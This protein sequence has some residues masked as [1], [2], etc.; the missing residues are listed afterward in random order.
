MKASTDYENYKMVSTKLDLVG[1][2]KTIGSI[3]SLDFETTALRPDEGRVRLAQIYDGTHG[4]VIDFDEIKGGFKAVASMFL[5]KTWIVFNS[6]FELRWFYAVGV[7]PLCK[8]VAFLRCSILGGGRYSLKQV[9][10]W[11]LSREMDK[12]EQ[13]SDWNAP[14][15]TPQQLRYAFRDAVDTWDLYQHW[16]GRADL[17]HMDAWRMFDDMVPAIIEMEEAGILLDIERHRKLDLHWQKISKDK[18]KAIREIVPEE[19]VANINSKNQWSDFFA[20]ILDDETLK[21]WPRTEKSGQLQTTGEALRAM[22]AGYEQANG[23]NPMT[24]LLDTLADY[25]KVEKY[26]SSFGEPLI[27]KAK[28]SPDNRIRAR[29]NIAAAKTCRF[30]SSGPNL[31]QVPRD[32]ELL[33]EATSVRTS[34]VAPRNHKLVSLDYSGIELRVLALLAKDDQLLEDVV[35]GDVHSEVAAVIAGHKIDKTT[36]EGKAARSKAKGVSFGI[37]YG[38]AAAGLSVNM[39]TSVADAQGYIDFWAN[40]Y[41]NAF[42][43]RNKMMA[44]ARRTRYIRVID[45]GTIYMGKTPEMPKCANYPVQR[46]ALS[47]MAKAIARHKATLDDERAAG[48]QTHTK[49]LSTIHDAIIDEAANKDAKGCLSL[50]EEDMMAGYLDVFPSGPTHGLVEGGMGPNWGKL[51]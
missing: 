39:R 4:Y 45:G 17:Q 18:V 27:I 11:D 32:N 48:R 37:I 46:A 1:A 5:G 36:P 22:A 41:A 8:D 47:I 31:Q 29:F 9:V 10:A 40:R 51:D 25:N 21:K 43:Y 13:A 19:D 49:M 14:V 26:I 38:S 7:R 28:T 30:S 34:F 6:G 24:T 3:A 35:Y 2:L 15:L 50:M 12:T 44:E 23:E 42:D 33:G 16:E 20:R